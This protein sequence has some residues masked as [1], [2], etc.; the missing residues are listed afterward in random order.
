[1]FVCYSICMQRF[2]LLLRFAK[3]RILW[4]VPQY[5]VARGFKEG[6][7]LNKGRGMWQDKGIRVGVDGTRHM[8]TMFSARSQGVMSR[9]K[10]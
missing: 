9:G 5:L 2:N 10:P 8:G 6:G 1:M 7:T 4:Y 3:Y